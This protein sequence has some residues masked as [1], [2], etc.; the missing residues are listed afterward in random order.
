MKAEDQIAKGANHD[1]MLAWLRGDVLRHIVTLKMLRVGGAAIDCR[2]REDADGWAVLSRFS[3]QVFEYDR[4]TYAG[5]EWVVLIDGTS[6][7]AKA[8]LLEGLPRSGLVIKTYDAAVKEWL[9][10]KYG[11]KSVRSFVSFT[12][13]PSDPRCAPTGKII[14]SATLAPEIAA[15]FAANGYEASELARHFADDAHWFG[16]QDAGKMVSACMVFRNHEIVWEIG[17]VYTLPERRRQGLARQ[18]VAAALEYLHQ[19]QRLPRYQ[20]RS[21]NLASLGLAKAAGLKEFLR[22]EHLLVDATA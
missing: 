19:T 3:T 13:A 6:A 8:K 1:R 15:M 2:L 22:M 12:G 9:R 18:V 5:R 17:G 11:A 20:V 21:D 16:I 10:R 4:Q 7:A 14:E